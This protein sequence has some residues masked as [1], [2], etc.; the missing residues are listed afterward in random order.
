MEKVLNSTAKVS[1]PSEREIL[2]ERDFKVP[3][4]LLFEAWTRPEYVKAWYGCS[5]QS[6]TVC[7]IDLRVGGKWRWVMRDDERGVDHAHS[8]EYRE[9]VRPDSLV[10]TQ[11]YEPYPTSLHEVTLTFEERDGVTTQRLLLLHASAEN[12]DGHL[13]S[14]MQSGLDH[15][16]DALERVAREVG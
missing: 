12:R 11:V 6:L 16:F 8:G 7:E 10:F 3:K 2:I 15:Q 13:K 1:L 5:E 4:G 14:G 9:I